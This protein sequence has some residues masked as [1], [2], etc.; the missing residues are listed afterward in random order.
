MGTGERVNGSKI[1][2]VVSVGVF[3]GRVVGEAAWVVR[4]KGRMTG[5]KE[6]LWKG[7]EAPQGFMG[8]IRGIV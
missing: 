8:N 7:M 3:N 5:W 1:L 2:K 6:N 4:V